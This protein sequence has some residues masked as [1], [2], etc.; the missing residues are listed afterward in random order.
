MAWKERV[1]ELVPTAPVEM[2][3]RNLLRVAPDDRL[4]RSFAII[5]RPDGTVDVPRL[6][7]GKRFAR[8]DAE[9]PTYDHWWAFPVCAYEHTL[10]GNDRAVFEA[11]RDDPSIKKIVLTRSR[12]VDLDGPNVVVVPLMSPQGQHHL[13]RSGQVFVKHSMRLN[14]RRRLD[15][16]QHN[17]INL[18]HGI[19]LKRFGFAAVQPPR[20]PEG[21]ARSHEASC[22]VITSSPI[23][24]AAMTAALYPLTYEHMWPTGLP[25]NDFILAPHE[26][27]PADFQAE[28][29]R[30]R[31]LVGDRRLVLFLPT[32]K[33]RQSG[34][35]YQFTEDQ[36][37]W[38]TDWCERNNAVLGVREHAANPTGNHL[39]MLAPTGA[40]NLSAHRFPNVEVLYRVGD[41][42]ISDYSSC[43]VDFLLTGRPV[44]SF[45]YDLEHYSTTERGLFYDLDTVVPGPVP[46]TFPEL[47]TAL[48]DLF[49]PRT[50]EQ[51]HVYARARSLFF[52]HLDT[53]NTDRVVERV[54]ELYR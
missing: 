5:T 19:P 48:D 6:F 52:D 1:L 14:V 38:L 8:A 22:A 41:A 42:L 34:A 40:L 35:Y 24:T 45:A 44:I 18:W 10:H 11:V 32:S 20:N 39:P 33:D 51:R 29:Q 36:I 21:L 28:E 9:T 53:G 23:D 25:R 17:V 12:R 27:L 37:A 16:A 13:F 46:R 26:R 3:E 4:Q 50:A 7:A 43:L 30:L 2:L 54:K 47:A 15:P 49:T 31:D